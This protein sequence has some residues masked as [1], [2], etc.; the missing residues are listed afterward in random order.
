MNS[1]PRSVSGG[2]STKTV[3]GRT[4][5]QRGKPTQLILGDGFASTGCVRGKDD[6]GINATQW[7]DTEEDLVQAY[8]AK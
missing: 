2:T 3:E 5:T 1:A 8:M 4:A 6:P 7:T